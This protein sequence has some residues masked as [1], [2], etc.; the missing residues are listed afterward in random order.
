MTLGTSTLAKG[1][2]ESKLE[3][4]EIFDGSFDK[5]STYNEVLVIL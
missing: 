3:K 4:L 5:I 1:G 2:K